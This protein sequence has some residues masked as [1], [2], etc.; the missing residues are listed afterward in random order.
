[1]EN[2]A[3]INTIY[4]QGASYH[5]VASGTSGQN[6]VEERM[7]RLLKAILFTGDESFV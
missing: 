4:H 6:A 7:K 2:V 3:R 5:Q 1:M